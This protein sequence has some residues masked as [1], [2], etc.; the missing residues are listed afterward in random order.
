MVLDDLVP[1]VSLISGICCDREDVAWFLISERSSAL[2]HDCWFRA[3]GCVLL[4]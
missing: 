3:F 2:V 4:W 1:S